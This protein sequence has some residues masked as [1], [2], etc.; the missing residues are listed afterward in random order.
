MLDEVS[1]Y[2][3]KTL[4][5]CSTRFADLLES[6]SIVPFGGVAVLLPGD[7]VQLDPVGEESMYS[8]VVHRILGGRLPS[9]Y[10]ERPKK[11]KLPS[12]RSLHADGVVLFRK[13][14]ILEL[15]LES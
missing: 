2:G 5:H 15:E 7:F 10:G 14:K 8:A 1:T 4:K 6:V 13:F 3:P 12:T 9:A 11:K